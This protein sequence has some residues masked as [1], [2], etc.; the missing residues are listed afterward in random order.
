MYTISYNF[1]DE[2][3]ISGTSCNESS[4]YMY[5]DCESAL[6]G[7][8]NDWSSDYETVGAWMEVTW[9]VPGY[10]TRL[11]LKEK[12]SDPATMAKMVE[13]RFDDLSTQTVSILHTMHKQCTKINYFQNHMPPMVIG[14]IMR[15]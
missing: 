3:K 12:C 15:N 1:A 8:I 9:L 14:T 11:E 2:V 7:S 13:A 5:M 4:I 10:V 6:D